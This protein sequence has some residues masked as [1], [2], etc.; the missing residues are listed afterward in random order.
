M[1]S[2]AAYY[3]RMAWYF[4][5]FLRRP[6]DGDASARLQANIGR[7]EQ[8]FLELVSRG[9]F[10]NPR[11]PY[12]HLMRLAGCT[13]ADLRESTARNGLDS[14][15]EQLRRE[16]VYL[17]H[18]E[19]KGHAVERAGVVIAND[20]A[21]TRNPGAPGG[22]ES[23][24]SGSRSEGSVTPT[25]NAYRVY[26]ENYE[27]LMRQ[28]LGVEDR[29]TATLQPILP[30]PGGIMF[31]AGAAK[32]GKPVTR[33]FTAGGSF[34]D[35]FHYRALT[36]ILIRQARLLG[37]YLPKP[38]YL[39]RDDFS[40]VAAWIA[41]TK[42]R[43][44]PAFVR[45]NVSACTRV[46]AAAQAGNHDIEGTIFLTSGEGITAA[47]RAL[48]ESTRARAYPR[49]VTSE[50][51]TIGMGCRQLEG[52]SVHLF[53]DSVAVIVHRRAAPFADVEVDS[54]LFTSV[55]P[56]ASRV[57][58]NAELE[59]TGWIEQARCDCVF[60]RIGYKTVIREVQSFGKLSGHGMTLPGSQILHI[61]EDR[62]PS[63]FGGAPGDYQLVEQQ[64]KIQTEIT[65][66]VSPRLAPVD[67]SGLR[68]F[69]LEEIG[70]VFGGSL[71]RRTWEHASSVQVEIAEPFRTRTGK[72][73][74]VH[75][76]SL[77]D[78]NGH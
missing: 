70:L 5:G 31:C 27:R 48:I 50:I 69:F 33:W 72:V 22:I 17:T 1:L 61:L 68:T 57:F 75:L 3:A 63:R 6:L 77:G 54:L 67:V 73:L 20:A 55:N 28:E 74:P 45:S 12:F 58:I 43:G 15:L 30:A 26:R 65:L 71:A 49:Y 46:C 4:A 39:E 44:S 42:S 2:E 41:E 40:P 29:R 9:V 52:N 23:I 34:A 16:G 64:G 78:R 14:T 21:A 47:K 32:A 13:L 25:S 76:T 62:L 56:L 60:S 7:R 36:G 59:D 11:T 38:I 51:G 66:R 19:T 10:N 24:S 8:N 18:A 53:H 37:V 35:S